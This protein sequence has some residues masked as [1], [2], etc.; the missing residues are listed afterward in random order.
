[1]SFASATPAPEA[2]P[3]RTEATLRQS[4]RRGDL[5]VRTAAD[6]RMLVA[7]AGLTEAYRRTD[8]VVAANAEFCE[9]ASLLLHLGPSDPPVRVR[10]FRLGAA[11]GIGGHGNTDLMLPIGAGGADALA[12]LLAGNRLPLSLQGHAGAQ[13]PRLELETRLNLAEI[14]AGQLLLHRGISENGVVAVNSRE[15]TVHTPWGPVLGPLNT[16]LCSSGGAGSIGL[17]MPRLGLLGPGSPVLIAGGVGWVTGAGSGHN[18]QTRRL[19]SGHALS[20]GA[21]A[22]VTVDLHAL[23]PRWLRATRLEGGSSGLMVAIAAPVPL[24]NTTVARQ[25]ACGDAVLQAPVLDFGIPRRIRPSFGSVSYAS[26]HSGAL[27]LQGRRVVCAPGHSPRL[28]EEIGSELCERLRNGSF[29]LRLP[30][31][32]L[33]ERTALLPLD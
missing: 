5:Q 11:E 6:Y 31:A 21:C 14:G 10:R 29:P 18:P 23:L 24:I 20:P 9:Q 33:P 7:E 12:E 28:A 8:V 4:Q 19:P 16:A 2:L 30:V 25:A 1:M 17:T 13:Q 22:A 32:P 27:E 15:G 3:Q 26:L